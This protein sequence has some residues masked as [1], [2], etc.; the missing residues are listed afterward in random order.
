[1]IILATGNTVG[2]RRTLTNWTEC[3]RHMTFR[4]ELGYIPFIGMS[5]SVYPEKKIQACAHIK[6]TA[7]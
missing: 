1:M 2:D 3:I 4:W 6:L 5:I 7:T